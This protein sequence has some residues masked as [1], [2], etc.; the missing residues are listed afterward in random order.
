MAAPGIK[1]FTKESIAP[2][3]TASLQV[4]GEELIHSIADRWRRL[5]EETGSAP[6]Q[7]PEWVQT[8]LRVFEPDNRLVLLT[9]YSAKELISVLPLVRKRSSYACIP[10][11]KLAGAANVHSV[12]FEVVRK[13][14]IVGE[15]ALASMWQ[16]LQSMP[17]WDVLELPVFPQHG[18][19][20]QLMALASLDGFNTITFLAQDSPTLQMQRDAN[21]VL[22]WLGSTTRHFRHELRR[23]ER[24]LEEQAGDKLK[25][26]CHT[27]PHAETLHEFYEMEAA[28]WKGK[29]GTA[30]NCD[31]ATRSFY[32]SVAREATSRGYF[33]LHSLEV[34]GR[35]T[36]GAFSVVADDCFFPMKITY[37][38]ALGHGGPGQVLLNGI[39]Q[40]CAKN[41]IPELFF[42]GGK[43]HYKTLWTSKTLPHFNGFVFN[44]NLRARLAFRVRT[45]L[46]SPMG[47]YWRWMCATTADATS[48]SWKNGKWKA[49]GFWRSPASAKGRKNALPGTTPLS[50][51]GPVSLGCEKEKNPC[52]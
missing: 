37:D 39:M 1:C 51:A 46:L 32:D 29:K 7:R 26:V 27:E 17:G 41:G 33:R 3:L 38:E 30:I 40:E 35:M 47:R 4:G 11:V 2:Q 21:G 52:K 15:A 16:L 42:G 43:D 48:R 20:Q 24:L 49:G 36:A 44:K 14:G 13:E 8:Y 5:C 19:C 10:V 6:F 31:Q 28:G 9:V 18:A 22:T 25:L 45:K 50:K 34:N 23:K 12:R